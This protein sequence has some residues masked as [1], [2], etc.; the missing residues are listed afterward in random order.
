MNKLL[1]F[2]FTIFITL[3]GV[4]QIKVGRTVMDYSIE[5]FGEELKMN[6]SG[7]FSVLFVELYSLAL[8]LQEKER[9]AIGICYA[10]KTMTLTTV[11]TSKMMDR[12]TFVESI[13]KD[14]TRVT[15]NNL[16]PL[17][18]RLDKLLKILKEPI[19]KKDII[20]FS[21]E[22]GVG[23]HIIKNE[24][25]LGVIEGQDF[26]F[27]L[28]KIWLGEEPVNQNLKNELLGVY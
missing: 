19:I 23:T 22:K 17:K 6:G 9:D 13:T 2:A 18:E 16:A 27:A 28:F 12:D 5:S 8:Y 26:K 1:T 14:L 10:D 3:S 20:S 11:I 24:K 21:Y 7:D 15:D 25:E 4:S